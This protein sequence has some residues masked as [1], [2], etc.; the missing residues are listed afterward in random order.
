M[1]F[2]FQHFFQCFSIIFIKFFLYALNY[3]EN[4]PLSEQ[5][6]VPV[7]IWSI[8]SDWFRALFW[9]FLHYIHIISVSVFSR[10]DYLDWLVLCDHEHWMEQWWH[11]CFSAEWRCMD[12]SELWFIPSYMKIIYSCFSN[13][14][15]T[16]YD[17]LCRSSSDPSLPKQN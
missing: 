9:A 14:L 1:K 3:A 6:S 10:K 13:L 11:T 16:A 12:T 5:I 2:T 17:F 7:P 15:E 4:F 8:D